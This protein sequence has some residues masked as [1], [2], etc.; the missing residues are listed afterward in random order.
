MHLASLLFQSP[1]VKEVLKDQDGRKG[2][3]AAICAGKVCE[4][5]LHTAVVT[6]PFL[7]EKEMIEKRHPI[8]AY[9]FT[10]K[11]LHFKDLVCVFLAF[12]SGTENKT[13]SSFICL[14]F[15]GIIGL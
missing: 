12:I 11:I 4:N 7:S 8:R 6:S 14:V 3:I 15:P 2:L 13:L 10:T 9:S 1:A 5:K